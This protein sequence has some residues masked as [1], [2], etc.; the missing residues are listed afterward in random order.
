MSG[1]MVF[2]R[3]PSRAGASLHVESARLAERLADGNLAIVALQFDGDRLHRTEFMNQ[4]DHFDSL[5]HLAA[6]EL[7]NLVAHFDALGALGCRTGQQAGN[8]DAT[9]R[10][11]QLHTEPG[12]TGGGLAEWNLQLAYPLPPVALDLKELLPERLFQGELAGWVLG[13]GV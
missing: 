2:R 5:F 11:L 10:V 4:G 1:I 13:E 12:L 3:E 9:G 8:F 7:Q 6:V